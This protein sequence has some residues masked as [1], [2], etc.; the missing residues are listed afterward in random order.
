MSFSQRL[1]FIGALIWSLP[2]QI[3]YKRNQLSLKIVNF[4]LF[5]EIPK[6]KSMKEKSIVGFHKNYKHK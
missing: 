6:K 5:T 4:P 3:V 2:D 1:K